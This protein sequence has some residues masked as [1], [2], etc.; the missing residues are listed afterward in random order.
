ML[1]HPSVV[2]VHASG[3]DEQ[4]PYYAMEFIDGET[5]AQS[6]AKTGR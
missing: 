1:K 2:V 3:Q 5:L 4:A 6:L